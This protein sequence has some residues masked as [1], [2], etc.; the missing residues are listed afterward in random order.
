MKRDA[1]GLPELIPELED[2]RSRLI[3]SRSTATSVVEGLSDEEFDRRPGPGEWS[4]CECIDHLNVVGTR[5]CAAFDKGLERAHREGLFARGRNRYGLLER[6][7]ARAA[8]KVAPPRHERVRTFKVYEPRGN[9]SAANV[10]AAY[11]TLQDNLVERVEA[12]NG[13]DLARLKFRSPASRWVRMSMGQ[14][15]QLVAG[16]QER[17]LD[18]A[19][20]ARRRVE[21]RS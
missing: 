13:I 19:W 21:G 17:R 20:R 1:M 12:A 11:H 9:Q 2:I 10:L 18:Q 3:A 7:F 14:W 16:H 5:L 15:L 4:V 6:W 8:S